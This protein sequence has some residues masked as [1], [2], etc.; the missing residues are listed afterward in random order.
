MP[1]MS[2]FMP[3]ISVCIPFMSAFIPFMSAFM[4][5][6]SAFIPFM[7]AFM[8]F[9]SAFMPFMSACIPFMSAFI[10][11]MSAFIPFISAFMPFISVCILASI[12]SIFSSLV[13][14]LTLLCPIL[15]PTPVPITRYEICL[16]LYDF[17]LTVCQ[18]QQGKVHCLTS[19]DNASLAVRKSA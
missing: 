9:I 15:Y 8:S 19:K 5:F 14:R 18:W 16:Y 4:S 1:F 7:S 3:F 2:V 12:S 10:P 6:I 11:F 13:I 17:G